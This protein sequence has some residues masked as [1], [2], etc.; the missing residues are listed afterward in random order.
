[1][2]SSSATSMP[3][4]RRALQNYQDSELAS[5]STAL[6]TTFAPDEVARRMFDLAQG[7]N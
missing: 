4:L 5:S 6:P 3:A 2:A 1:M 7:S